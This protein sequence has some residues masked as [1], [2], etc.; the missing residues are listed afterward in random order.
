MAEL[1]KDEYLAKSRALQTGFGPTTDFADPQVGTTVQAEGG[2]PVSAAELP[3][4][5][6]SVDQ[7]P[8]PQAAIAYGLPPQT[9][10]AHLILDDADEDLSKH[11]Q[12]KDPLD[13]V[14]SELR[15]HLGDPAL[16]FDNTVRSSGD[17]LT[18]LTDR[19]GP[20][21]G[22]G[23]EDTTADSVAVDGVIGGEGRAASSE[24]DLEDE[25]ERPHDPAGVQKSGTAGN[26]RHH[27]EKAK[28]EDAPKTQ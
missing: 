12:G 22:E 8:D 2:V 18:S 16:A 28:A 1:T 11:V 3:G 6:F 20:G 27:D 4:Q 26:K 24:T 10:P 13:V 17:A 21:L 9:V 7:L 23:G 25:D 14:S 19:T 5:V 15:S